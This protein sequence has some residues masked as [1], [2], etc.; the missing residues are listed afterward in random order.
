MFSEKVTHTAKKKRILVV[1]KYESDN[2]RRRK[3]NE[4]EVNS[5]P[6][7][8]CLKW[9]RKIRKFLQTIKLCYMLGFP[10]WVNGGVW[11]GLG[12]F[13]RLSLRFMMEPYR[14]SLTTLKI[15]QILRHAFPSLFLSYKCTD[16]D[17][18]ISPIMN[19]KRDKDKWNN[20]NN[21]T[22]IGK[23]MDWNSSFLSLW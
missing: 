1:L 10:K 23:F 13:L 7:F 20:N 21:N 6:F 19:M 9:K 8:F 16:L 22:G 17:Y 15:I 14:K 5:L 3:S 12:L 18:L 4:I 2:V 11:S